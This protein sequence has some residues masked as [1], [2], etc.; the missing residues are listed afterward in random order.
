VSS[1]RFTEVDGKRYLWRDL[2]QM[3]RERKNA[4]ARA[5][6]SVLVLSKTTTA[7]QPS[8]RPPANTWEPSLFSH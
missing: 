8:A 3:R 2:M 6:Q 1:L 4:Q 5:Q 7:P